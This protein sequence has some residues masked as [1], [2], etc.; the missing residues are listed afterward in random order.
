MESYSVLHRFQRIS[1]D[2]RLAEAIYGYNTAWHIIYIL[3]TYSL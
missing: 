2:F 3:S 1:D